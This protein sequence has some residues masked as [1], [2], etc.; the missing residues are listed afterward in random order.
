LV[1]L[2]LNQTRCALCICGAYFDADRLGPSNKLGFDQ[3]ASS[4]DFAIDRVVARN[5]A[6]AAYFGAHLDASGLA[7]KLEIF[8]DD[9]VGAGARR[10]PLASRT[11]ARASISV[12]SHSCPQVA[13][14]NPSRVVSGSGMEQSGQSNDSDTPSP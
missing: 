5:K 6:D 1:S 14:S 7:V 9:D 13:H 3:N 12:A 8:D 10:T 2:L 4:V 11:L